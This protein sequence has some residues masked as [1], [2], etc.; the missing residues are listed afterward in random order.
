VSQDALGESRVSRAV[1]EF[2]VDTFGRGCERDPRVLVAST[3]EF[4]AA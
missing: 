3:A 1:T 4:G 2:T